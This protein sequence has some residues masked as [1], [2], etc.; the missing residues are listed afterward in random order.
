[1]S[2]I[3]SMKLA[4][5]SGGQWRASILAGRVTAMDETPIK[6]GQG[7]AGKLKAAYLWPLYRERDEV[8]FPYCPR[9]R[10]EQAFEILRTR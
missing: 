10:S 1:M 9:R 7:Q 3:M 5:R 2:R 8:C 6:A 4:C